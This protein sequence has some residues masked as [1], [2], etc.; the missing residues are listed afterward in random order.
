MRRLTGT[1][2]LLLA[3]IMVVVTAGAAMASDAGGGSAPAFSVPD[4]NQLGIGGGQLT[5]GVALPP[6]FAMPNSGSG[7]QSIS[8]ACRCKRAGVRWRRRVQADAA[9]VPRVP[10]GR[11][12]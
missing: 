10:R 12:R 6:D 11:V 4:V 8:D 1:T 2:L 9:R 3:T 7:V 5:G